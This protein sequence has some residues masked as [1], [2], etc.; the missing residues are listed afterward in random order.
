MARSHKRVGAPGIWLRHSEARETRERLST[1][2]R[3]W[4][5]LFRPF[6][7]WRLYRARRAASEANRR[8][9]NQR[10]LKRRLANPVLAGLN[11]EQ[12]RAVIVQEDR[13]LIVAGA[14][15]GKTHTMVEKARDTVRTGIARPSEIAFVTFTRKAAQEIRTRS[16]DLEGMEIGTLHHLARL[17]IEMAEGR[18]PRL[19]PLAEDD[20]AR[21]EK[22]ESWLVEAVEENP[23]LLLDLQTR[24]QAFELCRAPPGEVPPEPR[25]PPDGVRVRSMGEA[26]IATTLHLAK[27]RYQ[28]EAEFSV[29]EEHRSRNGSGYAPDFYLPDAPEEP[30]SIHGGIWLE[31]FA[32][33]ANGELPERWDEDEPGS[34]A[35]YREQRRWKEQ[36]HTSLETRFTF[37]EFGDIQRCLKQRTSFPDL[38]L[39]RIGEQGRTGMETPSTW[40]VQ[41]EIQRLKEEEADARHWR[42]AYEIDAWIRTRRQQVRSDDGLNTAISKRETAEEARA[43]YKL[44]SPVLERYVR[45]LEETKTVDH[46][47][48]ILAGW[49]YVRERAVVPPWTVILVDEYQDV[50]PAQAA[51]VHALLIPRDPD[52][53]STAARLTAVGDDWQAIFGFQGG[54]VDLIRGFNDPTGEPA[55][56][57]ERI[58]LRQTYRFGQPIADSTRHFVTRGSGAVDR[59]VVGHPERKPDTRWPSS[60]VVASSRLTPDGERRFG[61]NHRGVTAGVLAALARIEEQSDEAEVLIVARKNADLEEPN[62]EGQ[63]GIGIDRKTINQAGARSGTRITYSTVHK[64]KGTEADFVILLDTGPP[65]AGEAASNRALE[66]ALK[67]FRGPDTPKEEERRIWYV[68]L[69]RARRKVYVIVAADTESHSPYVDELYHNEEGRYD[70]G[71]DELAEFLVPM[72]PL[73]PCPA[74]QGRGRTTAV[75]AL[76]DRSSG[77]FAGCTS[78]SSGPEHH[79]GHTERVCEK[80]QQG[81]MIRLGNERA[82]CQ[83]AS[84]MCESPLCQCTVPRPMVERRNRRTGEPFWGCQRYGMESS[85]GVTKRFL[86]A[87]QSLRA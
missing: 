15:T 41:G 3:G 79:C 8:A 14:G 67:V 82:R 12:R 4:W 84:C 49:Q 68:A 69:T 26:R 87:G 83:N 43:L 29:P 47:G 39:Q 10:L 53:P 72:R 48:T 80:C 40:D 45:H 64:A 62:E 17:V 37:T 78:F 38:L 50:N 57:S 2:L 16:T 19:S 46:E 7:A 23:S 32:N 52:R 13:P 74:C 5:K 35:K 22:I 36:L 11:E 71:E 73:V 65:R 59:E 61:G 77:R 31:H 56:F 81:L 76:R 86:A 9:A 54:D 55:G 18:K 21:L 58:E 42:I 66:S 1:A 25:V 6:K 51:F 34:T 27:I 44:A 75:L 33:D 85:C 63:R 24:R 30:A 20:T 70:V 60:I 28:Y